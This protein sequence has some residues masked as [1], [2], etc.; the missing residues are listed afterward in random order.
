MS[1]SISGVSFFRKL[2]SNPEPDARDPEWLAFAKSVR[3]QRVL[4]VFDSDD[5]RKLFLDRTLPANRISQI[6]VSLA[7][8]PSIVQEVIGAY[9]AFREW[10]DVVSSDEFLASHGIKKKQLADGMVVITYRDTL[11]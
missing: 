3:A 5:C 11:G 2:T 8:E 4:A 10:G 9:R 7:T 1:R 6:A